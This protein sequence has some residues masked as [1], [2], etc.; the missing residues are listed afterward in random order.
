MKFGDFLYFLIT[1]YI[2]S[3]AVYAFYDVL[4][5]QPKELIKKEKEEERLK[6]KL[7]EMHKND[8]IRE[9]DKELW[10]EFWREH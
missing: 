1:S 7:E 5:A 4:I 9:F 8:F 3:S 10:K 6:K 2:I